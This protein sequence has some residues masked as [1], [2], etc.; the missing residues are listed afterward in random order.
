MTAIDKAQWLSSRSCCIMHSNSQGDAVMSIT[1]LLQTML[2][3]YA[4]A[5]GGGS[6][7]CDPL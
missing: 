4:A 3:R 6:L 1:V 5:S 2:A 7:V